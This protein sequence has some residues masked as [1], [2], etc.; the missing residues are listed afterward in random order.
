MR[1]LAFRA[2]KCGWAARTASAAL[3]AIRSPGLLLVAL[4]LGCA[5]AP[6]PPSAP[7]PL[8]GRAAPD[9]TRPTLAGQRL[10]TRALRGRPVVYEFFAKYC[11][12]CQRTLPALE[13]LHRERPDLAVVGI[14]EDERASEAAEVVASFGLTF[15]VVHDQGNVL[16]GRF[17]VTALPVAF[18]VDREGV[19]RWVGGSGQ[20]ED[21]LAR[22]LDALR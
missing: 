16:S 5:T 9:F 3:Q 15:P 22:A 11:E 20:G 13:R 6:P 19:V 14:A 10:D 8:V 1:P 2:A 17:R 18:L 4:I 12:P 21:D 7:S